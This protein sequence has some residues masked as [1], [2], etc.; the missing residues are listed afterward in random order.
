MGDNVSGLVLDP[1]KEDIQKNLDILKQNNEEREQNIDRIVLS[2][3]ADEVKDLSADI[4]E[5]M[6][7]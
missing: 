4:T 5:M 1:L 6:K 2:A 7:K 3:K